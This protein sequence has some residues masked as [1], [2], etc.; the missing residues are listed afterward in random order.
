MVYSPNAR[1]PH[2]LVFPLALSLTRLLSTPSSAPPLPFPAPT[3]TPASAPPPSMLLKKRIVVVGD[4]LPDLQRVMRV[5]PQLVF[6]RQDWGILRP[7]VKMTE[8]ELEE[9]SSAGVYCAGFTDGGVRARDELYD[10][11]VDLSAR[12]ITV[13][14]HA[15]AD[16]K[17]CQVRVGKGAMCG[18][19]LR[20]AG[21]GRGK[22]RA[23]EGRVKGDREPGRGGIQAVR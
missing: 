5:L 10:V 7:H 4:T 11:F 12:S 2:S 3:P 19:G 20:G 23:S 17:L 8:L 15:S 18:G 1:S 6:H 16:M 13:A 21:R 22:S 9:L 14:D